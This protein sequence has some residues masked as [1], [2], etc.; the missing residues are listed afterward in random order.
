MEDTLKKAIQ[1]MKSGE[2]RGFNAVYSAT[3]NRVYFRAKQIMKKEEDAQDLTQIVFVEAYKNIHTL[4]SA[5]ALYSWL[6][7]IAYNQGM[8]IFSKRK[9]VLLTEEAEG[10]FDTLENNDTDVMPELTAQ[11][12]ATAEIIR[13]IIEELPELQRAAVVAYYFDGLK[14]ERIAEMME[15]SVNTIKSRL[16]YARK[17]IK[18]RVEEKE[19]KEGYRLHVLGLPVLWYAIKTMSDRTTLTVEAAQGIYNGACTNVGLKA[20]AIS[21]SASAAGTGAAAEATA[22]T[23]TQTAGTA[24]QTAGAATQTAAT[25]TQ[26]AAGTASSGAAGA[27]TTTGS[28]GAATGAADAGNAAAQAGATGAAAAGGLSATAKVLMIAGAVAVAGL[29]TAGVISGVKSHNMQKAMEWETEKDTLTEDRHLT[30]EDDLSEYLVLRSDEDGTNNLTPVHAYKLS[31]TEYRFSTKEMQQHGDIV[32]F[33]FSKEDLDYL[34]EG[35][36]LALA[37]HSNDDGYAPEELRIYYMH[38]FTS[39]RMELMVDTEYSFIIKLVPAWEKSVYEAWDLEEDYS[40]FIKMYEAEVSEP[41]SYEYLYDGVTLTAQKISDDEYRFSS[42]M[43]ANTYTDGQIVGI[44]LN[45]PNTVKIVSITGGD[46]HAPGTTVDYYEVN[47]EEANRMYFPLDTSTDIIVKV[48]DYKV[49]LG[50]QTEEESAPKSIAELGNMYDYE[51][52]EPGDGSDGATLY[53]RQTGLE[54]GDIV[55]YEGYWTLDGQEFHFTGKD[56]DVLELT[57]F[58]GN[59]VNRRIAFYYL[60]E[61]GMIYVDVPEGEGWDTYAFRDTP[62]YVYKKMSAPVYDIEERKKGWADAAASAAA[63]EG[64]SSENQ[65]GVHVTNDGTTWQLTDTVFMHFEDGVFTVYGEGDMPDYSKKGD[66]AP[67]TSDVFRGD[68]TT[69]IIEEGI[70]SI[71]Y[72]A[73]SGYLNI[74]S[75]SLPSTLKRIGDYAFS[76]CSSLAEIVIPDGVET[77]GDKIFFNSY[78]LKKIEIPAS[79]TE[80]GD[81][82]FMS[83][84]SS[85]VIYGEKGSAA[86]KYAEK[87][88]ITFEEK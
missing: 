68:P 55:E 4:Q 47:N 87:Y 65:S 81:G 63:A 44:Q 82:L 19:E 40:E 8:K 78:S 34:P 70:T 45:I 58:D 56:L 9:D 2:E 37:Y 67:W 38:D 77:L 60:E 49:M 28:T 15:C 83:G 51:K 88:Q 36:E 66:I 22:G 11:Q 48:E 6:D 79:V 20:G 57:D 33:Y 26:T 86:E 73:F 10:L 1:Q 42:T 13:G 31:D 61:S 14:V 41:Y 39:G 62:D 85:L 30:L 21:L 59:P 12:K 52:W 32:H 24:T 84:S 76:S 5:E 25:A 7:G 53:V 71:S 69:V 50:D 46:I 43:L 80:L 18:T 54:D 64:S 27:G 17:Y 3:Y 74:T 23:A 35:V 16:N 75:V 72:R 29:G